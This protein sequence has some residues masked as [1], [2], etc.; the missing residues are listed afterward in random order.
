MNTKLQAGQRLVYQTD[1]DGFFV[2]TTVADPDPKNPGV[3]LIP[4]GCV[5]LAPPPIGSGKKAIWSGY[6][7]KVIDM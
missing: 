1:Q 6:K 5:E 4:A 7:W 2:G 3:W